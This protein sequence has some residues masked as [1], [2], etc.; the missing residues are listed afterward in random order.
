[1][2]NK[3]TL[4]NIALDVISKIG[5]IPFVLAEPLPYA[6]II[7]GI[8]IARRK[9]ERLPGSVNATAIARVYQGNGEFLQYALFDAP[10]EGETIP[11]YVLQALFPQSVF[12][13][14]RVLVPRPG[15]FR[16]NAQH[17][18]NDPR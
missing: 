5:N 16:A 7:V 9:K 15:L 4:A 3:F 11:S 18:L 8:D 14:Q 13:E 6:D 17:A 12:A 1:M 10:L 2:N